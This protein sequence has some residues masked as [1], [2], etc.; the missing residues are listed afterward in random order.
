MNQQPVMVT[1]QQLQSAGGLLGMPFSKLSPLYSE[2]A[3][4]VKRLTNPALVDGS[5]I[6]L[7]E[8][9]P[10][11]QTLAQPGYVASATT[12]T[13]SRMLDFLALFPP[14]KEDL[15]SVMLVNQHEEITMESPAPVARSIMDLLDILSPYKMEAEHALE[16]ELSLVGVWVLFA[17]LDLLRH[18]D[19]VELTSASIQEQMQQPLQQ[20]THISAFIRERLNLAKPTN[21][22]I[23]N[24]LAELTARQ[25]WKSEGEKFKPGKGLKAMAADLA[26]IR[27]YCRLQ[28]HKQEEGTIVSQDH[29]FLQG[30]SGSGLLWHEE[31]GNIWLLHSTAPQILRL[32]EMLFVYDYCVE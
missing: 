31:E 6:L 13:P 10:A 11:L 25:L 21:D 26:Y 8:V 19:A 4:G 5:G 32:A 16:V 27:A 7:P 3:Q 24:G 17:V 2:K 28:S 23:R 1:L 18:A 15:P 29:Y 9:K 12:L 20:L 30:K 14:D 22:E